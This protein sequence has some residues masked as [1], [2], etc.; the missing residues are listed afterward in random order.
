[1]SISNRSRGS[2]FVH[3]LVTVDFSKVDKYTGVRAVTI[4]VPIIVLGLITRHDTSLALW[5]AGLVLAIDIMR[6]PGSRTHLL[7]LVS[8]IY[9]AFFAVGMIISLVDYLVLPL[10]ALGVF[11][12]IYLRVFPKIFSVL[13][14]A[15]TLFIFA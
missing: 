1:M 12:I 10:L 4:L 2:Q 15:G 3:D 5:A 14:F 8:V 13:F 6:P 9:T 11:F 7:L